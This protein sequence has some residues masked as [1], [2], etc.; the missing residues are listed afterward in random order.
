MPVSAKL[1]CFIV[2]ITASA[3]SQVQHSAS[4]AVFHGQ[5]VEITTPQADEVGSALSSATICLK[6][7]GEQQCYTPPKLK[8][9]GLFFGLEPH[10]E[11]VKLSTEDEALLFTAVASGG[12]SGTATSLALLEQDKNNKLANLFPE[13]L[14]ITEQGEYKFWTEASVSARPLFVKADYIWKQGETHFARHKFRISTYVFDNA[15]RTY[16][17]RDEYITAKKYP[18][19]DETD[20][21]NVLGFEK[22]QILSRLKAGAG[23][24]SAGSGS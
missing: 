19:L 24:L 6:S 13:G 10:A 11:I 18:S 12:G 5:R 7:A 4:P 21:I 17:L 14:T 1:G 20:A 2:A 16:R 3:L 15:A 22:A 8:P 9:S 23:K